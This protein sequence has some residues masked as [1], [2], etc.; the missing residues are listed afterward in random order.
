M[1]CFTAN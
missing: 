1:Y